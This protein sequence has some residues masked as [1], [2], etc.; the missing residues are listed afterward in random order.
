M[1]EG[2]IPVRRGLA[3]PET[4][5]RLYERTATLVKRIDPKAKVGGPALAWSIEPDGRPADSSS[6]GLVI[7]MGKGFSG[8]DILDEAFETF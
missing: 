5:Y 3:D 2:D 4:I 8:T 1:N 6:Q 7:D